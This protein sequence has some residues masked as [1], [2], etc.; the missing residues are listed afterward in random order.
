[1]I[2]AVFLIGFLGGVFTEQGA[3]TPQPTETVV[4]VYNEDNGFN[5]VCK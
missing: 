3:L 2:I 1:M 4:H 5:K